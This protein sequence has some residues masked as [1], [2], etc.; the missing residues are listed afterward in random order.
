MKPEIQAHPDATRVIT[1]SFLGYVETAVYDAENNVLVP[2][3]WH[4][5]SDFDG[6]NLMK[7]DWEE[8]ITSKKVSLK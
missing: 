4:S 2:D 1:G 6:W 5:I 7:F 3:G 8:H